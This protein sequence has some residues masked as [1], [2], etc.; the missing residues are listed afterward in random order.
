[1]ELLNII[2]KDHIILMGLLATKNIINNKKHN[3]SDLNVDYEYHE[4]GEL[5]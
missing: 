1:M 4:S 3:L 5:Q 2:I